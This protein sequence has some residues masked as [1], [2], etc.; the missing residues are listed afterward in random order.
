MRS[1]IWMEVTKPGT[2]ACWTP[3]MRPILRGH[4]CQGLS[5]SRGR[6]TKW[7]HHRSSW[8]RLELAGGDGCVYGGWAE[9]DRGEVQLRWIITN[10]DTQMIKDQ[11]KWISFD[12]GETGSWSVP[13]RVRPNQWL[14]RSQCLAIFTG[15]H[16]RCYFSKPHHSIWR[17]QLGLFV[18]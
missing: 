14:W 6:M 1:G 4:A 11:S 8:R 16:R 12:T 17:I 5:P 2:C 13:P 3:N 10:R 15:Y 18:F 7:Q 9:F